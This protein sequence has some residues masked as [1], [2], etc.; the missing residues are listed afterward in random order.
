ML[1]WLLD[2]GIRL[3]DA[4]ALLVTVAAAAGVGYWWLRR[5]WRSEQRWLQSALAEAQQQRDQLQHELE[6]VRARYDP[7]RFK[8]LQDHFQRVIAHE[9]VKG[10]NFIVSQSEETVAGLHDDQANLRDRQVGVLAKAHEM[11]QHARNV[12]GLAD[13]ER[14]APQRELVNLRGLLEGVSKELF[15]YAEAQGVTLRPQYANPGPI[16]ANRLL[17]AQLFSNVIHN[18]IKYSPS[19]SVVEIALRLE[20]GRA[21]QAVIEIQ[22]R[23]RGIAEKDRERIFQLHVRGDGLVEPGSGLGLYYACEIARLHGGD[24]VLVASEVNQGSTFNII[25][26]YQ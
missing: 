17:I 12:V 23:G 2:Y 22:D 3:L 4:L 8:A 19:G 18:A 5:R 25:L 7:A 26:P 1:T 15:P 10:L 21:K 16:S 20:E 13:L 24:L 14:N 11:I 9:F 6:E